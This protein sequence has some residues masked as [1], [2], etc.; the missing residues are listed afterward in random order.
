MELALILAS[1][2][3]PLLGGLR[4]LLIP[5]S[6][7][8]GR[9]IWTEGTACVTSVFVWILI[10]TVRSGRGPAGVL[11]F[12]NGFSLA[13]GADGL[14][15]LFAGMIS[16]MW[17]LVLIYA[18]SYME[19]DPTKDR[20][21]AFYLGT[22]GI[23]LG[24]AFSANLLTLYVF[25]EILTLITIPLVA[26][27]GDH[28]SL[29]AGRRYAAY[30]IG[31]ASLVFFA[32][33]LVTLY[34]NGA[35]F[36]WSGTL[37]TSAGVH[38]IRIAYLLGFFG[39]GVKAAIFPFHAWLPDASAA[40]TPVTAL[41]H[42]V[43][44]VNSGVFAVARLTW[45]VFGVR[46]LRETRLQTFL[47]AVIC[48]S[49]VYSSV[50]ALREKHVKRRLAYSTMSNLS[51]MLLGILLLNPSGFLAGMAHMVFHSIIKMSLFLCAGAFMHQTGRAYIYEI[52]GVGKRM[53]VTFV[54]FTLGALSLIGIPL[55]CG[56]VSKWCLLQSAAEEGTGR[57]MAGAVCLLAAAFLCAM[58]TLT[59]SV[60]AFFPVKG[61]DLYDRPD[62]TVREADWR[63]LLPIVF[64]TVL[65]LLYGIMPA[66]V[67]YLLRQIS[68]GI[69]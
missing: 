20:F 59:I 28:E 9:A 35:S 14:S 46:L 42:A 68:E 11:L 2:F 64:F 44:V 23:S 38:L 12:A 25:Y 52:N 41:L 50:M 21:F 18:F 8:R 60:R 22:Y 43:A 57:G 10:L 32:V 31:G 16:V 67:L 13:A 53:P 49:M 69:W 47:L 62:C 54:C 66:P 34:G 17:P 39:F 7:D 3:L 58:Y 56:F 26:H 36:G 63:M 1:I 65:N 48:F 40:P 24:I 55:F 33:I 29:Y 6:S 27:Y 19:H 15:C 30:T 61:S 45:Y 4:L 37:R 51:Y 5:A